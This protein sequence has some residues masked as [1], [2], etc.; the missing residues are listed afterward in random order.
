[1]PNPIRVRL[2]WPLLALLF[3]ASP[4]Y[5]QSIR[6]SGADG[7]LE[8]NIRAHVGLPSFNCDTSTQRLSRQLPDVRSKLLRASSALGY[9]Q[10]THEVSFSKDDTCW[11][12]DISVVPGEAVFIG[13]INIDILSR[14]DLFGQATGTSQLAPGDQLNHGRY[15]QIKTNLS[16]R[17]IELGFFSARFISSEILLDLEKNL[18]AINISFDPGT[19][20]RF[21][22]ISITPIDE[23]SDEFIRRLVELGDEDFYS[24]S[25]LIELRN[26][27]SDSQYFNDITVTPDIESLGED[28]VP[29][30]VAL[31]MLPQRVYTAGVGI[32]TDIGP[33]VRGDYS[34]RYLNKKGHK[35]T[36][37]AGISPLEQQLDLSYVIPMRRPAIDKLR[38]SAG[39]LRENN[40]TFDSTTSR[41][42]IRYETINRW[43][44][45]QSWFS[46]L[47]NDRYRINDEDESSNLLI[48]GNNL[49]RTVADDALYPE[50]GW[51][52]FGQIQGASESLLST[53]TFGQLNLSAKA[54]QAFGPGRFIARATLGA[55]WTNNLA[56]L[57]VSVQY[58]AGGD[59][60]IRGYQYQ[61]LGPLNQDGE[62]TGGKHL[63]TAGIEYDFNILP[64]WKLALFADSGNAFSDF[65]EV[66]FK[67][68]AGMGVRWL[69]PIGPVRVDIA[70]ALDDDNK[71]RLHITMGP[72]F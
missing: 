31:Q 46:N 44:W 55:T 28:E 32:T 5:A 19:H 21:G 59:Q 67:T 2:F 47:Q 65:S 56:G 40:D 37:A 45:R 35:V 50:R 10:L 53:E 66:Q 25:A 18:A 33:R 62:V 38:I 43:N 4:S 17:A 61:S 34:N 52:L 24:S 27:L 72:E 69:S 71:L 20:Y 30:Q 12:L 9:Y 14:S 3:A 48:I 15:E 63:L 6:V 13:S 36:A 39:I 49:T 26:Q 51:R 60:S 68:G 41:L 70:S 11:I 1:M 8:R 29:I 7:A 23:L 22:E 54:V 57:P 64:N 42:G 16:S 58:F